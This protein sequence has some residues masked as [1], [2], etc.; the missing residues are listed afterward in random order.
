MNKPADK[1][2]IIFIRNPEKGKVKTRLAQGL[3]EDRALRIYKAL[4]TKTRDTAL[5]VDAQRFLFYSQAIAQNDGWPEQEFDKRLQS[6]DPD[7]G[8]RMHDSFC[9]ALAKAEKAVIV[10]SDIAQIEPQIL[11]EAFAKL[12]HHD[13]V[14]GPALDGGYYLLGMKTPSPELFTGMAWSTEKVFQD[15][16]GRIR[17]LN[18]TYDTVPALSDIDFAEDWEKHGWDIGPA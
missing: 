15:T 9:T 5:A 14:I 17:Q 4:L 10:G 2:L 7:L 3:G 13:Y 18:R 1:A 12:A 11:E 8:V 6:E 16:V